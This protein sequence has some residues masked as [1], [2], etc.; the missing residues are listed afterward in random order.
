MKNDRIIVEHLPVSKIVGVRLYIK[1]IW[2]AVKAAFIDA[3]HEGVPETKT[4]NRKV[5]PGEPGYEEA[6]YE[7]EKITHKESSNIYDHL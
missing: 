7:I 6:D 2:E 5:R 4:I 1:N 3:I